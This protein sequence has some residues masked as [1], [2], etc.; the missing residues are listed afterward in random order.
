MKPFDL[1]NTIPL[2]RTKLALCYERPV[3]EQLLIKEQPTT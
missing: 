1:R 3:N 2:T